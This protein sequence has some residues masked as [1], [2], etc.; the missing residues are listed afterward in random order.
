VLAELWSLS[1][2]SFYERK[3]DTVE[4]RQENLIVPQP[5]G[6]SGYQLTTRVRERESRRETQRETKIEKHRERQGRSREIERKA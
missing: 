2:V 3:P 1:L 4:G 5:I 6:D